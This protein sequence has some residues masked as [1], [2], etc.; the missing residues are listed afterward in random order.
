MAGIFRLDYPIFLRFNTLGVVIGIG[1]FIVLGYFCG[2]SLPTL[3][4]WLD[5]V[6]ITM[7][8]FIAAGIATS[9][10]CWHHFTSSREA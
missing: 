9:L 10:Y 7:A 5:K 8:V 3:L 4:A 1:E 2:E 6:S